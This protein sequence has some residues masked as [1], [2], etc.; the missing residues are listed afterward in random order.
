MAC[1]GFG[2]NIITAQ[3]CISAGLALAGMIDK[4][5]FNCHMTNLDIQALLGEE[6]SDRTSRTPGNNILV[7]DGLQA[8]AFEWVVD[9]PDLAPLQQVQLVKLLSKSVGFDGMVGG[10]AMDIAAEGQSLAPVEL[11]QVHA[12]KTGALI[13]ASV[14]AGAICANATD[15]QRVSLSTFAQRI[16]LAFQV[17]DDV[18]DVTATSEELGKTAGKDIDA[19]K[20]TY[21]A[22][23]G[24]EGARD[25]AETLLSEALEALN[26]FGDAASELKQLGH[27]MVHRFF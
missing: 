13:E 19:E 4:S 12:R 24:I 3:T 26:E 22:S 9:T 21:V 17:M 1:T 25:Y 27:L 11:A 14:V 18:L 5:I 16:G 2:Q 10:Q 23:M 20:S 15:A 7:G 6:F 8:L